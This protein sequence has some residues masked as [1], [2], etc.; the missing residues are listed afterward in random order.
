MNKIIAKYFLYY[1]VVFLRGEKILRYKADYMKTQW[2]KKEDLLEYQKRKLSALVQFSKEQ[3][4]FYRKQYQDIDIFK[5]KTVGDI[6]ILPFIDKL[7]LRTNHGALI[8]LKRPFFTESKT[9]GGS[10]GQAVS[11]VKTRDSLAR[12]R[13]ATWRAY[14]WYGIDIGD[15]QAKFWGV[16]LNFLNRTKFQIVDLVSN[17]IRLSAFRFDEQAL[18]AYYRRIVQYKPIYL[19]GYVSMIHAFAVYMQEKGLR[20]PYDLKCVI[21]TSE[22]LTESHKATME[23]VF[24]C[25]VYNEYGCGE[26]GSIAHECPKGSMHLMTE[27]LV[28][29][30]L[31]GDIPAKDGEVGEI[32]VTELNNYAMPL[33]RYRLSDFAEVVSGSACDCGRGLPMIRKMVGRAYDMIRNVEGK[34]FHGEFFMYIFEDI[35]KKGFDVAQFQVVQ[36]SKDSL[37]IKI[38][39]G[40][41][42][43]EK[44]EA[45]LSETIKNKMGQSLKITYEFVQNIPREKSGKVRL[46]KAMQEQAGPSR[47][48]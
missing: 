18:N 10:T 31:N 40:K 12:E 33:I 34:I 29:E 17:R 24:Q 20:L 38:V 43:S 5:I 8:S 32:V 42:Y 7:S 37:C 30:I 6:Q 27:N 13:A 39:P 46:I 35:K 22:V 48:E 16:P 47:T 21:T 28:V 45:I 15:P 9:T 1:P 2:W 36:T 41:R 14:S 23:Q 3:V 44:V 4:P 25:K 11:I 26:V 19:Y